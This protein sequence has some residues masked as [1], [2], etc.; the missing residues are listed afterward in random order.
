MQTFIYTGPGR[1]VGISLPC[2]RRVVARGESFD[3]CDE[4]AFGL[5]EQ[6]S[7]YTPADEA[8][9]IG[10]KLEPQTIAEGTDAPANT[11]QEG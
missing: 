9:F 4:C 8:P 6:P 2:G 11:G 1:R 10:P 5:L 7:N 3:V